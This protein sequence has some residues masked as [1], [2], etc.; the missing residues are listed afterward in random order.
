MTVSLIS[1]CYNSPTNSTCF[2]QIGQMC[3]HDHYRCMMLDIWMISFI[4]WWSYCDFSNGVTFQVM[5]SSQWLNIMYVVLFTFHRAIWLPSTSMSY[6]HHLKITIE[7]NGRN[8][9]IDRIHGLLRNRLTNTLTH[10][11]YNS[12]PIC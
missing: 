7:V 10:R 6:Y 4:I 1:Y 8:D 12:T 3:L 9:N 11:Q 5:T 2:N